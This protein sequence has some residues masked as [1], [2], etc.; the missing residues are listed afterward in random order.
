MQPT[1]RLEL[2]AKT[3]DGT[4]SAWV[5]RATRDFSDV[6]V[7]AAYAETSTRLGW[8]RAHG[9][10]CRRGAYETLLPPGPVADLLI[11]TYWTANARNAEEGRNVFAAGRG[12]DQDR[13]DPVRR[14]RSR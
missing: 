9:S 14:C 13:R 8:A 10:T 11:Y 1:G 2:N 3:A 4:A 5:G 7:A 12:P 6:D